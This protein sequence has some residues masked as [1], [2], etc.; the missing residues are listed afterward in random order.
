M[1]QGG[2]AVMGHDLLE[3]AFLTP[4]T[5]PASHPQQS[6]S[7]VIHQP[8]EAWRA[9]ALCLCVTCRAHSSWSRV[10][11]TVCKDWSYFWALERKREQAWGK[12]AK[13]L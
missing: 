4:T 13:S 5:S 6:S 3:S 7:S 8:P 12:E 10:Q 11:F 9:G 1:G 2:L